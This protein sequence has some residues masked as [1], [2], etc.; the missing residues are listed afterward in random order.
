VLP[1]GAQTQSP[2]PPPGRVEYLAHIREAAHQASQ[3]FD[4]LVAKLATA[5]ITLTTAVAGLTDA[6]SWWMLI[7]SG[8]AFAMSLVLSL[9]SIR[10]SADG[11]RVLGSGR[12]E[13]GDVR[14]F[15]YVRLLNW[16][17]FV[18]ISAAFLLLAFHLFSATVL[19]EGT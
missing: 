15:R 7:G 13:Y 1:Q 4:A 19:E 12:K 18:A 6:A 2:D 5:G 10:M 8:L 14:Q 16:L 3:D 11:L 9:L 17:A